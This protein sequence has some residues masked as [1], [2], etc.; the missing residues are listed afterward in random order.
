MFQKL[1]STLQLYIALVWYW[2]YL[3][4]R[5]FSYLKSNDAQSLKL[6]AYRKEMLVIIYKYSNNSID[7]DFVKEYL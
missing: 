6:Q 1:F 2:Q 3:I 4:I 7:F 5:I